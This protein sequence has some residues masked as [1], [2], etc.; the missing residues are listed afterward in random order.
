MRAFLRTGVTFVAIVAILSGCAHRKQLTA[1]SYNE[2][3]T[4]YHWRAARAPGTGNVV[5]YGTD[6]SDGA[7]V[8]VGPD[9]LYYKFKHKPPITPDDLRSVWDPIDADEPFPTPQRK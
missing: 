8:Y 9:G 2:R 6:L 5:Y 7:T 3:P 4:G 1:F